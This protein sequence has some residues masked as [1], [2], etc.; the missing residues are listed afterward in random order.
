MALE[1]LLRY[2]NVLQ[3]KRRCVLRSL[4]QTMAER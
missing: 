4:W 2:L 1:A 3:P